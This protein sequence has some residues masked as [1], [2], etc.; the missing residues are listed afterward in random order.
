LEH[1]SNRLIFTRHDVKNGIP[2]L[3]GR[4]RLQDWLHLALAM[5]NCPWEIERRRNN[6]VI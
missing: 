3:L 1:R 4:F 2:L 5:M 6:K